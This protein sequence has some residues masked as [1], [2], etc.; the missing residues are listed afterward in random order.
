V[1]L[2]V[3][4][5]RLRPDGPP[6]QPETL[7]DL[8]SMTKPLVTASLC[9]ALL[10]R[11]Q[12]HLQDA[13]GYFFPG[14][15]LS[16]LREVTLQQLLTHTSGLPP[17][18]R[19]CPEPLRS[20]AD[21]VSILDLP[22]ETVPGQRYLYTDLGYLLAGEIIERVSGEP[23]DAASRRLL[24]EPLGMEQAGFWRTERSGGPGE[25]G[26]VAEVSSLQHTALTPLSVSEIPRRV[27]PTSY[28]SVGQRHLL[29]Q[30]DDASTRALGGVSGAAGLFSTASDVA[31]FVHCLV[32]QGR[33]GAGRLF[34][35][36]A[37]ALMTH[38][39]IPAEV[40]GQSIGWFAAPNRG[41]VGSDLLWEGTFSHSGSTG[42]SALGDPARGLVGVL[43]TNASY[44]PST[45]YARIRRLYYN[46]VGASVVEDRL[47]RAG[48][49]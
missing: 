20:R 32:H 46:V 33:V 34:S 25:E 47:E 1:V 4:V 21:I 45:E 26:W 30:T 23:L 7:F 8:A 44:A 10:E 18:A 24:F 39:R 3:A 28:D 14:K 27:A 16:A 29:A 40:G 36:S 42:T 43:L 37:A 48:G 12:L 31:R 2:E 5:G 38:S 41:H 17:A 6:V 15:S 22:L 49:A 11:G 19:A 13:V 35:P 9:V